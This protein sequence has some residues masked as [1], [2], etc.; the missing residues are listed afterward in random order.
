MTT[1]TCNIHTQLNFINKYQILI[2]VSSINQVEDDR[3]LDFDHWSRLG[4]TC[5]NQ[6]KQLKMCGNSESSNKTDFETANSSKRFSV[7]MKP[8]EKWS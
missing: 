4:N 6:W 2:K 5:T 3:K 8:A 7:D 1:L